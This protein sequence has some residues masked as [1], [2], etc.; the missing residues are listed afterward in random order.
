MRLRIAGMGW[1]TP[2][3][4]GIE[5]VWNRLLRGEEASPSAIAGPFENKSYCAFRVPAEAL[6][7]NILQQ[8]K[9][10][11]HQIGTTR[12]GL[13]PEDSVVDAECRVHGVENLYVSS[14]SGFPSSSQANPTFAAV[15]LAL[16]L[17]AHL[18]GETQRSSL[19]AAA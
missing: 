13:K 9:D 10:G 2:L 7:A 6:I 1:V 14:S 12:M 4:S 3:G 19:G 8:A 5:T 11:Y 17:A 18:A 15:A 16:R